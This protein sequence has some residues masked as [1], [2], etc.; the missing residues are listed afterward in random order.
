MTT[1]EGTLIILMALDPDKGPWQP[2]LPENV[3]AWIKDDPDVLA[4]LVH[5]EMAKER[6]GIMWWRCERVDHEGETKQ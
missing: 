6:D 4:N 3:P 2:V 5:G 1:K